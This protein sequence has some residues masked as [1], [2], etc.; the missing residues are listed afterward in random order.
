MRDFF[1]FLIFKV[2][3][4]EENQNM[5]WYK[6][7]SSSFSSKTTV[8]LHFYLIFQM[9]T[10]GLELYH[11]EGKNVAVTLQILGSLV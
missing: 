7:L 3:A 1:F 6:G 9:T 8:F 2:K 4:K 5:S 10:I 11:N